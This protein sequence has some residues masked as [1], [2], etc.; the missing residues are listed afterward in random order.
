VLE[1]RCG[2][3]EAVLRARVPLRLTEGPV[4]GRIMVTT[5]GPIPGGQ[6]SMA[7]VPGPVTRLGVAASGNLP[8]AE[9]GR[10]VEDAALPPGTIRA[11]I[12]ADGAAITTAPGTPRT[13]GPA[14]TAGLTPVLGA[15]GVTARW[16]LQ[17]ATDGVT[18]R[19]DGDLVASGDALPAWQEAT[20]LVG[21]A[22]PPGDSARVHVDAIGFSGPPSAP[23]N[24]VDTMGVIAGD[25]T[26]PPEAEG[27]PRRNFSAASG[28]RSARLEVVAGPTPACVEDLSAD[29]G[30]AKLPLHAAVPGAAPANGPYC[31]YVAE[32]TPELIDQLRRGQ[33]STPIIRSA[34]SAG[35]SVSAVLEVGYPPEVSVSRRPATDPPGPPPN[36]EQ[37]RLAHL[38]A[39]LRNA[40][41][42]RLVEGDPVPRGRVVLAVALDGVAGQR[43]TGELAGIAGIEVRMDGKLIAGLPTTSDGPAAAGVYQFGLSASRLNAGSH[44]L[45]LRV[46]GSQSGT[47]PRGLWLSFQVAAG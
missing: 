34:R 19:R 30:T 43:E 16:D 36:G 23:P 20:V 25:T 46:L 39:E 7:V 14:A 42:E 15:P 22:A 18:L 29:F 38:S 37:H 26:Y 10:A 32:F 1:L 3:A 24:V 35:L 33:L 4:L 40:A 5:D 28:A 21:F 9:A 44:V 27:P 41:G 47:R 2:S 8:R 13:P 45:E 12:T 6:L 11:V 31:P 17:L